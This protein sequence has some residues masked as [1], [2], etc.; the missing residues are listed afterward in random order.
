[1]MIYIP[2]P[3]TLQLQIRWKYF[4]NVDSKKR[5]PTDPNKKIRIFTYYEFKTSNL[6]MNNNSSHLG[7]IIVKN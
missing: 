2:Q 7:G 4:K 5:T 6:V 3:D 1:M